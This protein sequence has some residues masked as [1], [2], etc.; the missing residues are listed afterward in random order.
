MTDR[1]P[2]SDCRALHADLALVR[3]EPGPVWSEAL[4]RWVVARYDDVVE[5]LHAPDVFSSHPTVP[6]FPS[7]WRERF[8]GRVP[9]R[10]TL[11]GLDTPDHDRLRS[12]VNTFFVP[13]TLA[14][15]EPWIREQAH[16][17]VDTF[18]ADGQAD[19]KTAFALPL[20]L[21][22]I[23]HIVGLDADRWDWIGAAL[24]FFLGPRDIYHPG[25]P[26]EKA[27]L[28]LDLHDYI[29]EVMEERRADRR[30]D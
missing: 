2:F 13:R 17:M 19:L 24:G 21:Q 10:G 16:R 25:T 8:A 27:E 30:D 7:P 29:R 11:I 3:A 26:E 1:C 15:F 6:Q 5:A 23:S 14:R 9:D 12:A 20:P 22:V 18:V 28:L 4:Q